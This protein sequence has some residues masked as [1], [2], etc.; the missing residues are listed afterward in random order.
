MKKL[1]LK[2]D[3]LAVESF[4]TASAQAPRGTVEGQGF[5]DQGCVTDEYQSCG[6]SCPYVGTCGENTCQGTCRASCY[7][8]CDGNTCEGSCGGGDTCY[9]TCDIPGTCYGAA[10]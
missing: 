1:S 10:C 3:E 9:F 2:L 4:E 6:G 8:T 5:T 7:G